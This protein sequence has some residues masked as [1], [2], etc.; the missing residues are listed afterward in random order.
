MKVKDHDHITRK[1]WESTHHECNLKLIL[2]KNIVAVLHNFQN[3]DSHLIFQENGKNYFKI[4]VIPKTI[5]KYTSFTIK[6][7]K[8][9]DV[10]AVPTSVF[11]G[12]LS[13]LNK[14]LDNLVKYLD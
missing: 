7:P 12:S 10:K 2:S 4:N 5:E 6:K 13:F 9:K 3:Y 11:I 14:S 1:Y 8:E